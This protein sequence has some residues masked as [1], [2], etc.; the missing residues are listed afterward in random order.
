[1]PPPKRS[2]KGRRPSQA[3]RKGQEKWGGIARR[4]ADEVVQ[5][6]KDTASSEW[7]RAVARARDD[8]SQTNTAPPLPWERVRDEAERAVERGDARPEPQAGAAKGKGRDTRIDDDLERAVE[9]TQIPKLRKQLAQAATAFERGRFKEAQQILGP[10]AERAPRSATVRELNGLNLYRLG[11]WRAA[12]REL[13][14]FR[15]LTDS[16]EQHPVLAD[17]YRAL[18]RYDDVEH[19]WRELRD[20]SPSAELVTE[21]R[22][23]AAGALADQDDLTS[24]IRVLSKGWKFPRSPKEHHLRRA[25][26]LADLYE[27]AGDVPQA[28]DLFA[29]IGRHAPDFGDVT[30]RARSLG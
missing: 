20:A 9:R 2:R 29:R 10:L 30:A 17:A 16:T 28:R 23:V 27:R 14:A 4:G 21:G 12:A 7:R 1:M 25:Y 15:E 26:A 19:L 11:R 13:E 24:A 18:G 6:R 22:I 8:S 5:P 3:P